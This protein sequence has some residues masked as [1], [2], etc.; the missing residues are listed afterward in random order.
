[1][2]IDANH[3]LLVFRAQIARNFRKGT[4][5]GT[6]RVGRSNTIIDPLVTQKALLKAHALQDNSF[7]KFRTGK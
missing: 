2:K 6:S 4:M 7:N 1:M 3:I 5:W